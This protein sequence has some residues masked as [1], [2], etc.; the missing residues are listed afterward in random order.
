M[1]RPNATHG[2]DPNVP[3]SSHDPRYSP[4]AGESAFVDIPRAPAN[5][6]EMKLADPECSIGTA[7]DHAEIT[8]PAHEAVVRG[9]GY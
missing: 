2:P 6:A 1:A 7:S 8:D 9:D 3:S 5:L 4:D